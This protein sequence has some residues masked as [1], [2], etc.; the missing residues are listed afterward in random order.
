MIDFRAAAAGTDEPFL[1]T[2]TDQPPVL[3][4]KSP[5]LDRLRQAV[6]HAAGEDGPVLILGESG[7][8]KSVVA[9]AV[10]EQGS[11][12]G[13]TFAVVSCE[14]FSETSLEMKL[15]GWSAGDLARVNDRQSLLEEASGGSLVLENVDAMPAG[16]QALLERYLSSGVVPGGGT[17]R[18]AVNTRIIATSSKAVTQPGW[19]RIFASTVRVPSLRERPADI[20]V[21]A[22]YFANDASGQPGDVTFAADAVRALCAYAWPGNVTQLEQV[23]RRLARSGAVGPILA[24]DL[25]VGIRPRRAVRKR[26]ERLQPSV[27]AQLFERLQ[28]TGESFWAC[29]YPLFM[30]RENHAPRPAGPPPARARRRA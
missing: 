4:G 30:R 19:N 27:G 24:T 22:Q 16:A 2:V 29:V 25:P 3:V 12:A 8:G 28:R 20:P 5:A 10:H 26:G 21:L 13:R 15:F 1:R 23:I 18:V 6:L 14:A 11:R 9:R 17:G 7:S